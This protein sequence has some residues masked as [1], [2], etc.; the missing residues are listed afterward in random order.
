MPSAST[1]GPHSTWQAFDLGIGTAS[2][3]TSYS[4]PLPVQTESAKIG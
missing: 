3:D 2:K 1:M 4:P